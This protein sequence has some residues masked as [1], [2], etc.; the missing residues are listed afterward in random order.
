MGFFT[1]GA[2]TTRHYPAAGTSVTGPAGRFRR[3]KTSSARRADRE[4]QAWEGR[5]RAQ[6]RRG[7]KWYRAAR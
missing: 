7:G 4:G 3:S 6:E 1:R 2:Q 5:D